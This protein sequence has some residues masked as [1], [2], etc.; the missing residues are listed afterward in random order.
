ME[1]QAS[2]QPCIISEIFIDVILIVNLYIERILCFKIFP[3]NAV[4]RLDGFC[5]RGF[6]CTI[7]AK[8]I[9]DESGGNRFCIT[10]EGF[11]CGHYC[12]DGGG[13]FA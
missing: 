1:Y 8:E 4:I 7:P 9:V 5:Y 13:L 2:G 6:S 3:N 12:F 11:L 10:L